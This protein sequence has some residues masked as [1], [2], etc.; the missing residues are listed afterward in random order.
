[1][2]LSVRNHLL[3]NVKKDQTDSDQLQT[4]EHDD[5]VEYRYLSIEW[6]YTNRGEQGNKFIDLE[7]LI[8]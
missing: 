3:L 7:E 1:M 2:E 5:V 8:E 6:V 4:G